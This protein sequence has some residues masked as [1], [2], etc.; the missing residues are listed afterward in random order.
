[1][2]Q[3]SHKYLKIEPTHAIISRGLYI[4]NPIF[5]CDLYCRAANIQGTYELN[6]GILQFLSLKSAVYK[7]EGFQIKSGL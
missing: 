4:F 3:K 7:Q 2:L 6:K 1:M 5:H